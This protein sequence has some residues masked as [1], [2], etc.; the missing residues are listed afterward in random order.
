MSLIE[1]VKFVYISSSY[2][3]K[4]YLNT[5]PEQFYVPYGIHCLEIM[6]KS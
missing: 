5:G 3:L 6:F 4:N 2:S 1:N